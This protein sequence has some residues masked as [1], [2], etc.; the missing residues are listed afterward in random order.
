MYKV[1]NKDEAIG[2]TIKDVYLDSL[3][4]S[5]LIEF[6]DSSIMQVH[7]TQ[8]E[9]DNPIIS[10]AD[11]MIQWVIDEREKVKNG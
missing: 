6:Y 10:T 1:I 2:K 4:E 5:L 3:K 11:C 7:I 8:D 9:Y